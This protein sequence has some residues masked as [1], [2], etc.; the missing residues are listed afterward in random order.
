ML[1][2]RDCSSG[3]RGRG[4]EMLEVVVVGDDWEVDDVA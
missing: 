3:E 2:I 4:G 1:R